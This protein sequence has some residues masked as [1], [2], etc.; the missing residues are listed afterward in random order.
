MNTKIKRLSK[1]IAEDIS[2][3]KMLDI[4]SVSIM[5][6]T[7]INLQLSD[8][9]NEFVLKE[10]AVYE[11]KKKEALSLIGT[12][13]YAFATLELSKYKARKKAANVLAKK[14]EKEDEYILLKQFVKDNFGK[15][16]LIGFYENIKTSA[17]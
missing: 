16:V 14:L 15:D 8:I 17:Q 12:K 6:E 1:N 7:S 10:E 5:I 3:L 13:S 11:K 9:V 4:E 2:Q